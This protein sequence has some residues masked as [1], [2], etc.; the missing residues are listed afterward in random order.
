MPGLCKTSLSG[1][2]P[3]CPAVQG[4]VLQR[5]YLAATTGWRSLLLRAEGQALIE[6]ALIVSLIALIA[7]AS[8]RLAGTNVSKILN[9]IAGEV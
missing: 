1:R 2:K 4:H 8:L 5:L 3:S 6:Y 9:T 7:I